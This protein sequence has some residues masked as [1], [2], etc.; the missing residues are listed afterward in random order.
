MPSAFRSLG[1]LVCTVQ[2]YELTEVDRPD[3]P[4]AVSMDGSDAGSADFPDLESGA[5]ANG[6]LLPGGIS[7]PPYFSV[8]FCAFVYVV[9]FIHSSK[10]FR[11]TS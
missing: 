7:V 5:G 4:S 10:T 1:A 8:E 2:L 9:C 11:A 6:R 3:S